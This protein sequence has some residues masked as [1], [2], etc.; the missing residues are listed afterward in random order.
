[1][2]RRRKPV[3]LVA[4]VGTG[5]G[6]PGLL[7]VR[8][9]EALRSADVVAADT[10]LFGD[11]I[12]EYAPGAEVVDARVADAELAKSLV[13]VAKEGRRVLHVGTDDPLLTET[14]FA[15]AIA[16]GGVPFEVVP[17]ITTALGVPTYAGIP[18]TDRRHHAYA[19]VDV[20]AGEP[21]WAALAGLDP[22]VVLGAG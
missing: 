18:L 8:A 7:T 2:S 21:A 15:T 10:E 16:R 14:D 19:V 20:G 6:D 12:N 11:L 22:V 17:G 9:V 3:G 5:P 4:L 13:R 1:M